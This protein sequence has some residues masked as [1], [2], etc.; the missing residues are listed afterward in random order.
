MHESIHRREGGHPVVVGAC[1]LQKG[2]QASCGG[3]H[4]PAPDTKLHG[5]A[6]SSR[7][8]NH[9]SLEGGTRA[10]DMTDRC[11][12]LGVPWLISWLLFQ[13]ESNDNTLCSR[14]LGEV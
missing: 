4:M 5:L 11:L 7:E 14:Q 2:G 8:R 9:F 3:R 6:S 10:L 12:N 13:Q 1:L